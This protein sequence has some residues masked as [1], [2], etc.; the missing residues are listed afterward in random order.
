MDAKLNVDSLASRSAPARA[1]LTLL[2]VFELGLPISLA[3]CGDEG[4]ISIDAPFV[5][6]RPHLCAV[7]CISMVAKYWAN[8]MRTEGRQMTDAPERCAEAHYSSEA[9][10]VSGHD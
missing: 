5:E 3:L 6:Q 4:L 2:L 7:A 9:R 8:Q 1:R 10:G